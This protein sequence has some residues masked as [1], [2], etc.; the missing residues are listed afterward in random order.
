[1]ARQHGLI[2]LSGT[3]DGINHYV[4]KGVGY[5][6]KAG[7]G[8]NGKAIRTQANMQRVRENA[9]EFG[10]CS[11]VKKALRIALLPFLAGF[12]NRTLHGRMMS[13]LTHIKALDF[14]SERGERRVG[15]GIQTAKGRKLLEEFAFTPYYKLLDT[16]KRQSE[17][18]WNTQRLLVSDFDVS[19]LKTPQSATHIGFSLGVLDFDFDG[20]TSTLEVSTTHFIEVGASSVSFTLVP[21]TVVTPSHIGLV[22]LGIRYYEVIENDVYALNSQVG[23][24]VL[25]VRT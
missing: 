3:L 12:K 22:V 15:K 25:E 14:D 2:K 5:S 18:D 9:S 24:G 23:V 13:L 21:E 4:I 1:M 6:R 16:L 20:L 8:F 10:H 19:L 17:F 7:G 11:R